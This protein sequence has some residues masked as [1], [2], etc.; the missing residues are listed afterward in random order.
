MGI[1]MSWQPTTA[2]IVD[3]RETVTK[4]PFISIATLASL[5]AAPACAQSPEHLPPDV[6]AMPPPHVEYEPAARSH[7]AQQHD[8]PSGPVRLE[9]SGTW[10]LGG[11][12]RVTMESYSG[13]AGPAS[14]TD[15]ERWNYWLRDLTSLSS[16]EVRCQ[17]GGNERIIVHGRGRDGRSTSVATWW[18]QGR[19]GW[20][21]G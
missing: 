14:Q 21:G 3:Q 5:L 16:V 12:G 1:A 10:S 6:A 18:W 4:R 11:P 8:C 20:S 2:Q 9:V 15:L 19:L 13:A 17:E 7:I